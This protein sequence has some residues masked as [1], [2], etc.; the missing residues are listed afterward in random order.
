MERS[1][2]TKISDGKDQR[3]QEQ[4][5]R[6]VTKSQGGRNHEAAK[7]RSSKIARTSGL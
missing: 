5:N 6:E 7:L 2:M 3:W 1:A 4:G